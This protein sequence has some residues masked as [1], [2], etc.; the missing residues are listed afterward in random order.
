MWFYIAFS[1][2]IRKKIILWNIRADKLYFF[3]WMSVWL[4]YDEIG[5]FQI[6]MQIPGTI[7]LKKRQ[8]VV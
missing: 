2:K 7:T 4:P 8:I 1:E 3:F 6:K 5:D